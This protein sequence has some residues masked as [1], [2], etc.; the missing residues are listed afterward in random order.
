M[1]KRTKV[2]PFLK[3]TEY[4]GQLKKVTGKIIAVTDEVGKYGKSTNLDLEL[5]N[6]ECFR[7]S[8]FEANLNPLIDLIEDDK[9]WI[10]KSI[11]V[12]SEKTNNTD[13]ENKL[14]WVIRP[15]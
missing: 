10:G 8:L 3:K 15:C 1:T 12:W 4:V 7:V 6:K 5:K 14:K 11:D 2:Y 13:G 9:D